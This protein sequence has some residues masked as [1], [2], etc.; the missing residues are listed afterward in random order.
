M[1]FLARSFL[2]TSIG[3]LKRSIADHER[4]KIWS[5]AWRIYNNLVNYSYGNAMNRDIENRS[6]T[7]LA[8]MIA[9][10]EFKINT[11]I[12][13]DIVSGLIS[14]TAESDL[15]QKAYTQEIIKL[16]SKKR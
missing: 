12:F 11:K 2:S 14:N 13:C 3:L 16:Q 5:L 9:K 8:Q 1:N 4:E 7:V 15:F 6:K 10:Y